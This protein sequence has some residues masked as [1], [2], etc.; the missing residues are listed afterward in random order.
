MIV[1][2]WPIKG[3]QGVQKCK[4]YVEDTN[5]VIKIDTD[6]EGKTVR[7]TIIQPHE[8][9]N[10]DADTLFINNEEDISRA[11]NYMANKEKTETKYVSGYECDP[12]TVMTDFNATWFQIQDKVQTKRI[13][14]KENGTMAF[15]MVQSFPEDIALSDEEVHQCGME[16]LKKIGKHQGLVCSHVHPVID[17]EGVPHGKCKHNHILFNA[18][19]LPEYLDPDHPERVKYHDCRETYAQLQIWN[20]EIAI[21]HGLPIIRD[22]DL[23]KVYSWNENAQIKEGQSWKER[24]RLDIEAA[25]RVSNNWDEFKVNMKESGYSLNDGKY[26]TYTAPDGKHKARGVT[27]GRTYTK[28][29]LELFWSI[30]NRTKRAVDSATK[31]NAAPPL[32]QI[33]KDY[34]DPL[35]AVIPLGT[36]KYQGN[37]DSFY[38]LPLSPSKRNREVLNSYFDDNELY[39]IADKDGIVVSSATGKEIVDYLES[40]NRGEQMSWKARDQH[41]KE[42]EEKRQKLMEEEDARK[43]KEEE[44]RKNR[45]SSDFR[46]SRTGGYYYVDLRDENGNQRTT[47]ELIFLLAV[48]V[49]KNESDLWTRGTA[50]EGQENEAVFGPIDWKIQNMLDSIH[51]AEEEGLQTP[52]DLDYRLNEAGANYSRKRKAYQNIEK[53]RERMATLSDAIKEY[54]ATRKVAERIA[55]LPEGPEKRKRQSEYSDVISRYK[56]A[57]NVMYGYKVTETE[58]IVDFKQRYLQLGVDSINVKEEYDAAREEYRRLKK[59]QHNLAYAQNA[60]YCYGPD[61]DKSQGNTRTVKGREVSETEFKN[62]QV[63]ATQQ[64]LGQKRSHSEQDIDVF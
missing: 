47:L 31:E 24:M 58:Q 50:P 13:H 42:E 30:R 11:V 14:N 33:A 23:D 27:L 25:R 59:L 29:S 28:E 55:A 41:K 62:R 21:D 38:A 51:V 22:P 10:L 32:W 43:K 26:I 39:N 1:K 6:K 7:R 35:K 36:R 5:K 54:E 12:N 45:Y 3:A 63:Q 19:V 37:E 60:Q 9:H 52:A 53:T 56:K 17:E 16:L 49:I 4:L 48:L 18:Y 64:N 46:N 15:H 44:E 34:S 57:K 2:I 61:Y 8:E 20:D 40:L